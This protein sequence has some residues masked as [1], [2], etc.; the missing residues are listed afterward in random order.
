M[1]VLQTVLWVLVLNA[2]FMLLAVYHLAYLGVMFGS[3]SPEERELELQV[4]TCE[5]SNNWTVRN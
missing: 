3:Q 4:S 5:L 2:A 1:I